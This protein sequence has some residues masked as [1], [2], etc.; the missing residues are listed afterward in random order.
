MHDKGNEENFFDRLDYQLSTADS[1]HL[2]L[3]F[4]RSWFQTPNSFD[5]LNTGITVERDRV[6]N[7]GWIRTATSSVPADQRSQIRPT[8]SRPPGPACSVRMPS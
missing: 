6:G 4:S 1:L 2:N 7:G 5:N 3:G 8:T